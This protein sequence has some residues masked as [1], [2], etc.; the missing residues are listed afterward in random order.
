MRGLNIR[1]GLALLIAPVTLGILA[2]VTGVLSGKAS[3]GLWVLRL[4]ALLGYPVALFTG[5]PVYLWM[6]QKGWVCL[7][8]YLGLAIIYAVVLSGWLFLRPALAMPEYLN[9]NALAFQSGAVLVG[10]TITMVTFWLIA[11][12]DRVGQ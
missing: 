9:L 4:S 7:P 6:T 5:F 1:V 12:P 8:A 11:R 3:E 10:C 2:V